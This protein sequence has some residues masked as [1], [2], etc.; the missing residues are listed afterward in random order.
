MRNLE[1]SVSRTIPMKDVK[2]E[3]RK[4]LPPG[5]KGDFPMSLGPEL[6]PFPEDLDELINTHGKVEVFSRF[7]MPSLRL[8][9]QNKLAEE[10]KAKICTPEALNGKRSGGVAVKVEL[11]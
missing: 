2:E 10:G 9:A 1:V 5:F 7:C 11:T 4:K 6:R 8:E 3:W